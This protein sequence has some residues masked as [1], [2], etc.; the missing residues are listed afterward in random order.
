MKDHEGGHALLV[1]QSLAAR[2]QGLPQC[3]IGVRKGLGGGPFAAG[4]A[5]GRLRPGTGGL[6]RFLAQVQGDLSPQQRPAG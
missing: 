5:V 1:R 6:T 3:V 4:S 2:S